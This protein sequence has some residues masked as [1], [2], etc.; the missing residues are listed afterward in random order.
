MISA[1]GHE[2]G[3]EG[4]TLIIAA[5]CVLISFVQQWRCRRQITTTDSIASLLN[6]ASLFPFC[7][8]VG[9]SFSSDFMHAAIASRA[10]LSIAGFL[11]LLFVCGEVLSPSGLKRYS[12]KSVHSEPAVSSKI[13]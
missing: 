3:S 11:G 13:P 7:L 10:S 12:G 2:I 4:I 6:G 5:V 8:M 1:F 9:A